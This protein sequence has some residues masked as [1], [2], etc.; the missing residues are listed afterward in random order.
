MLKNE[1]LDGIELFESD[2][3]RYAAAGLS[4]DDLAHFQQPPSPSSL[5]PSLSSTQAAQSSLPNKEEKEVIETLRVDSILAEYKRCLQCFTSS[6]IVIQFNS[7]RLN[8]DN[9]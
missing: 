6:L 5:S 4:A 3:D 8:S 2:A 7:F 9:G 1:G